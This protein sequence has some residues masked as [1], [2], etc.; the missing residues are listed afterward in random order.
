MKQLPLDIRTAAHAVFPSFFAGRNLLAVA[1]LERAAAGEG[2]PMLWLHGPAQVGKS[3]LLQA[4]VAAAHARGAASA[5]LPL[6]ELHALSPAL[7]EGMEGIGL[8]ALDDVDAVAG[9]AGWEAALFRLYEHLIQRGGRL[10]VSA[11]LPP[12]LSA[13]ALPDLRSRFSAAVVFALA[14]LSEAECREALRRRAA[15]RGLLLPDDTA[16]YLM[17]RVGRDAAS[18]FGWLDRLDQ[19][20]L[21]E[22]RALT[23][24]FVRSVLARDGPPLR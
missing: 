17:S 3:H 11:R 10:L 8:V 4:A 22:Q 19:A 6:A 15:W 23:I 1:T 2:P 21:V 14:P 16:R 20:S 7:L 24:P 5:Y 13:V 12:A 18:L 9:D